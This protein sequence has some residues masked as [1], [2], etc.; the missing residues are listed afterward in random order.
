MSHISARCKN[1]YHTEV[2]YASF[3]GFDS[4]SSKLSESERI[5]WVAP[6]GEKIWEKY[7]I[8]KDVDQVLVA[9]KYGFEI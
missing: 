3:F 5:V 9:A 8:G 4:G 1:I 2:E 6:A 7:E